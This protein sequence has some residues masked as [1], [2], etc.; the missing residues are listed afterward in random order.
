MPTAVQIDAWPG[1]KAARGALAED[2]KNWG[3]R[4][5][6]PPS[7]EPLAFGEPVDPVRW[8]HAEIG[9]GVLLPDDDAVS[10]QD[11]AAGQDAPDPVGR[12]LR[13]RPGTVLLRWSPK[14]KDLRLRRYY[15]D[16]SHQDPLIG[17]TKFGTAPGNW[18]PRYVLIAAPPDQIP[19][20][21]QYAL[22]P[23]HAVGR[24]PFT[25]DALGPYIDAMLA[26]WPNAS[27]DAAAP[28]LWTVDHGPRDITRLM[29]AALTE[30]LDA[31]MTGTLSGL[32]HL[33]GAEATVTNLLTECSR[34][35]PPA[36]V[37]TSSHGSTPVGDQDAL[38]TTLGLPVDVAHA[39]TPLEDLVAAFP[40][41]SV[42]FAQAC[43]SAGGA[44]DST[45]EGLLKPKT[46]AHTVVSEVAAL[47]PTVAPG[48]LRLLG[49]PNPVRAVLG[50]VEPTFS[51]TL[52][53]DGTGQL[54]GGTLVT[55]LTSNLHHGQPVGYAF[56]HYRRGVGQLYSQWA[57]DRVRLEKGD[58]SVLETL[59]RVRLTAVDRQS[60]VLLGDPT[61]TLTDLA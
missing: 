7:R 51:W 1:T 9:Y 24:L 37:V 4:R 26:G 58:A 41:G 39:T 34:A 6:L 15:P 53:A 44:G 3:A 60:L 25:G 32:R 21:V 11:K 40:A 38:R 36:L 5:G 2:A 12:L 50:H 31:A 43:C 23:A 14:L 54:L 57:G 47:G 55:A 45:Y 56:D 35:T 59:T 30:P 33:R 46:L 48:A 10:P 17:L 42:W 13:A 49:R 8:E 52:R 61:V 27:V 22:A 29:R 16:G 19:W 28:L 20:S 18:L